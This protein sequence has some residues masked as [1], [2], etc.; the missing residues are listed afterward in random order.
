SP[1]PRA[2]QPEADQA[3]APPRPLG[4]MADP[5]APLALLSSRCRQTAVAKRFLIWLA[6][7]EGIQMVRDAA[8]SMTVLRTETQAAPQS[9]GG[10]G[11]SEF[12][13]TQLASLQ[14]RPT[15][16]LHRYDRYLA[17]LDE[18]VLACLDGKATA[19]E[20]LAA[21]TKAWQ[22]LTAEIG[23]KLQAQ[24]WRQAQGLRN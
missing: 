8:P 19:Q 11:Y 3:V 22:S 23:E 6:G 18:Q 2:P 15:L 1:L 10:G 21:A 5:E 17:A 12:L 14:L 24:A 7:G 16:R 13:R 20:A 9:G 4:V